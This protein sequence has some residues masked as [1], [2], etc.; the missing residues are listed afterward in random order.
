MLVF[1]DQSIRAGVGRGGGTQAPCSGRKRGEGEETQPR[2][3]SDSQRGTLVVDAGPGLG[4]LFLLISLLD[5]LSFPFFLL[6]FFH[7]YSCSLLSSLPLQSL[8]CSTPS[9]SS[10]FSPFFLSPFH[11]FL[12]MFLNSSNDSFLL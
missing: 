10:F 12:L 1:S 7:R 4:I 5:S 3:C 9:L 2:C 11:S 6:F 8:S